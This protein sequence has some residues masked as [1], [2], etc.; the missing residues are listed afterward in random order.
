MH[1]NREDTRSSEEVRLFH[2]IYA[3]SRKANFT[4]IDY[5][6]ALHLLVVSSW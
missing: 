3:N 6:G 2:F 5:Y 4:V 1:E